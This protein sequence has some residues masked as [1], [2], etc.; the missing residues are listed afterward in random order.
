MTGFIKLVQGARSIHALRVLAIVAIAAAIWKFAY[1]PLDAMSHGQGSPVLVA[2]AIC[3]FFG[4][5]TAWLTVVAWACFVAWCF[6][7]DL[8]FNRT[9]SLIWPI[10]GFPI[11]VLTTDWWRRKKE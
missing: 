8:D 11:R 3:V 1:L 7:K 2:I 5:L 6:D 9:I 4:T 10:L